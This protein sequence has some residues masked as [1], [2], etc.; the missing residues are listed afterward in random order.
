ML[1]ESYGHWNGDPHEPGGRNGCMDIGRPR[2]E[3]GCAGQFYV[4]LTQARVIW[5]RGI[6]FIRSVGKPGECFLN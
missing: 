5:E 3:E 1:G 2:R 4:N 6:A